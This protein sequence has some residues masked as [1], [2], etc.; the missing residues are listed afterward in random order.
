MSTRANAAAPTAACTDAAAPASL[1]GR[2]SKALTVRRERR[3]LMA[4]DDRM[5]ADVGLS[6]ADAYREA[7]RPFLDVPACMTTTLNR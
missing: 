4:L 3:A 6:R 2:I 7:H 1:L 5:L